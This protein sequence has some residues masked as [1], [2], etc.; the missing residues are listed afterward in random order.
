VMVALAALYPRVRDS[1]WFGL[2]VALLANTNVPA[3]ILA[4]SFMLFRFV[5]LLTERPKA[6]RRQWLV[7]VGNGLCFRTIYPTFNNQAVSA[8]LAD[9]NLTT[10]MT[11][12]VD[13]ETGFHRIYPGRV[14]YVLL[15][16]LLLS[17]LAF[18]RKPAALAASPFAFAG[19]KFF[20]FF[21]YG[22]SYRHEALF[23]IF[24]LALFWITARD[25]GGHWR[26]GRWADYLVC[27]CTWI[28]LTLLTLQTVMLVRPIASNVWGVPYSRASE[29]ADLL[30]ERGLSSAIIMADPDPIAE[31]LPYYADNPLWFLRE[32]KFGKV[33][34]LTNAGRK[35]LT[36]DDVL[37]DASMLHRKTGRPVV[38]LAPFKLAQ[39]SETRVA[40]YDS[41]TTLTAES[42]RHFEASTRLLASLRPAFTDEQYEVYVYP[43]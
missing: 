30:E 11:A 1:L 28:F 33:V 19:L 16:V 23:L 21:I 6:G 5:E 17:C 40:M 10:I 14:P 37:A 9:L 38:F 36:L 25:G 34:R 39:V 27:F 43:R 26:L 22:S 18:V 12:L 15:I 41:T 31:T 20:F 13:G 35:D 8:N 4:G 24:I 42:V 32:Q 3:A 29:L 2:M 7:F